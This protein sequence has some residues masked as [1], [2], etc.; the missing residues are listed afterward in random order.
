MKVGFL[1]SGALGNKVLNRIITEFPVEFILTNAKSDD[2]RDTAEKEDI[3]LFVGN[4]RKN[5]IESFLKD[6]KTDVIFSV[7][8][9]FLVDQRLI[10]L[11]TKYAFNIHGSL[12]PKYRG[13]TPHVWAI[14]NNEKVTGIT[15]H[16]IDD[17]CDTGD[18]VYQKEI[19]I[20]SD[21][22]GAQLLEK[23]EGLYPE[24]VLRVLKKA[25]KDEL[26]F[27]TQDHEKGT[28]FGKRNHEDGKINWNWCRERI[29]NW[30]RA[31]APPYP[32]AFT[33]LEGSK[34]NLN[35]VRFSD[36]GFSFDEANGKVLKVSNDGFFV[37]TPNGALQISDFD[38]DGNPTI[39]TGQVL[40]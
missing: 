2:I 19:D 26:S 13:R 27:E 21:L 25:E 29:Y 6:K 17:G 38:F 10:Q 32:G 37:K 12:L 8:Y 3:P 31:L 23:F 34:L 5:N 7:N 16:L 20:E 33:F 36:I 28:Y 15:V 30:V 40:G 24:T 18:I 14:I 35:W 9:I 1:G 22:T 11:P 4:P 39:E